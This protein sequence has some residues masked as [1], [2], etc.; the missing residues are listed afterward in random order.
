MAPA[1]GRS[2]RSSEKFRKLRAARLW[3]QAESARPV[4]AEPGVRRVGHGAPCVRGRAVSGGTDSGDRQCVSVHVAV[5]GD[6]VD[7]DGTG[8]AASG[9][10]PGHRCVVDRRHGDRDGGGVRATATITDRV[11]EG[12]LSVP[13][14]V[15][16]E[17]QSPGG[18]GHRSVS[19]LRVRRNSERVTVR[20]GV[21]LQDRHGHCRVLRGRRTV[22]EGSRE[23]VGHRLPNRTEDVDGE[24]PAL[25]VVG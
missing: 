21:V 1:S 12:V 6:H 25:A 4:A 22:T 10:V 24:R 8:R 13:V 7:D 19:R 16:C 18:R 14:G 17:P 20:V 2:R 9:V 15:R 3:R 5:V 11:A 23:A